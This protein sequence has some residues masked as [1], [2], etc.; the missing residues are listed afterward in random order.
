MPTPAQGGRARCDRN[1][2]RPRLV[3]TM[4]LW[5]TAA[6]P[7]NFFFFSKPSLGQLFC[8]FYYFIKPFQA[9]RALAD[10][11]A[12]SAD[13]EMG[14]EWNTM[15]T[16]SGSNRRQQQH[17]KHTQWNV[18]EVPEAE[19]AT[20][21]EIATASLLQARVRKMLSQPCRCER[22]RTLRDDRRC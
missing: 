21:A 16:A 8:A 17:Q 11:N 22:S 20:E 15:K 7:C 6:L 9:S 19:S 13:S 4:Q 18:N 2:A 10:H 5:W 3:S 1:V 14:H 12:S